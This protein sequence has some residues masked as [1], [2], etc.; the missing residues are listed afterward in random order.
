[1]TTGAFILIFANPRAT[2]DGPWPVVWPLLMMLGIG[3]TISVGLAFITG[4][5]LAEQR[6]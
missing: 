2:Q 4:Y 1:M 5:G 6:A 3:A